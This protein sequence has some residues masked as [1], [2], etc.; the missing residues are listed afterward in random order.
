MKITEA[1]AD[2]ILDLKVR[3]LSKLDQD[4]LKDKLKE[5]QEYLKELQGKLKRPKATVKAFLQ[6]AAEAFK[7]VRH[8]NT[9]QF[10][11]WALG[12]PKVERAS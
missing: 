3:Q 5:Q 11:Y 1:Q 4:S 8:H 12:K 7:L 6:K 10:H 2:Q 9:P